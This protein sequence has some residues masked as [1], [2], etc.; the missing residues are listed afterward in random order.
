MLMYFI[1]AEMD[2]I[3]TIESDNA[4]ALCIDFFKT[5]RNRGTMIMPPPRPLRATMVP[6]K[7][8]TNMDGQS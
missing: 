5:M 6:A 1:K 8:P 7:M 3:G 4:V 2:R